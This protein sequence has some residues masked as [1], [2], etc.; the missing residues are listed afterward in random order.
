MKALRQLALLASV[1]SSALLISTTAD[2]QSTR[3]AI[4]VR[5]V[6]EQGQP[7][8]SVPIEVTHLPTGLT[9]TIETNSQG[10]LTASGLPVGGPYRVKVAGG[11]N[12]LAQELNDIFLELGATESVTVPAIAIAGATPTAAEEES[13]EEITITAERLVS[14]LRNGPGR[15][16]SNSDFS[17]VAAISRDF[18]SVLAL[19]SKIQ[20]DTSVP[21][22]PAVSVAG[23]NF[24]FN[25]ITIDGVPQND[26]FG[27]SFNASAVQR[28]P[29]AL[30]AIQALNVNVAPYDVTYGNFLGGN[31]N[32]VTK[33]GTNEFH[34][35]VYGY[36][37]DD[38]LTGGRSGGQDL[39]TDGFDETIF[40]GTLSGP[41]IEDKMFFFVSYE[42][43]D[44]T[45]PA[46]QR[47]LSSEE[48]AVADEVQSIL[49]NDYGFDPGPFAATDNDASDR[50]LAKINW[51][52]TNDHRAVITY[53]RAE[54][55]VIF[56]D[57]PELITLNSNRYNINESIDAYGVQVFSDWSENFSTEFKLGFK[58]VTNRQVS[59]DSS[60]P[61]FQ[62]FTPVGPVLAG[63]DQF[64][65]ANELDNSSRLFKL[66]ADYRLEQ[67]TLTVGIEQERV[68]VRNTF[69]PFSRG[70]VSFAS[71]DDLRNRVGS[72]LLFGGSNSGVDE[73]AIADFAIEYNTAYIQDAWT[74]TDTLTVTLG[75]RLDWINNNDE[76]PFNENFQQRN[77][78]ANTENLDGKSIFSPRLGVNWEPTDRL[79]VRGGVGRFGGGQPIIFLSNA[80]AGNGIT[81]TF[82]NF[83]AP[84]FGEPITS[85]FNQ[86]VQ[87]LPNPEA[88]ANQFQQ[89]LAVNPIG[90][91]DAV[92]PDFQ[93]LSSW[94]YS[95]GLD[96]V[97]DLSSI[98]LGDDWEITVDYIYTEVDNGFDID[99][100]RRSVIGTAPD[101]RPIYDNTDI[102]SGG[103]NAAD[104]VVTN[105]NQGNSHVFTANVDKV[106]DT[107]DYGTFNMS[108]G[109][110]HQDV[111]DV[112]SYGRFVGFETFAFDPQRDLNN[113]DLSNS[114]F[115]IENRIT[116]QLGWEGYLIGDNL[117]RVSL[118]YQGRSGRPVSFVYTG[119]A[120]TFGGNFLADAFSADNPGPNLFYVP[121]GINDPIVTGDAG[122][123][124]NLNE[125]IDNNSCISQYRGQI[126]PRNSCTSPWVN[127]VDLTFVQEFEVADGHVVE[128]NMNIL[129][130]TNLLNRNWGRVDAWTLGVPSNIALATTGLTADGSQFVY[131]APSADIDFTARSRSPQVQVAQLPS[132]Y[133]IQ[134]GLRYRF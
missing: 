15:D 13:V 41:I 6:N 95:L 117:S 46:N 12:F 73:D 28:T 85:A 56:D 59:I 127:T 92:S 132:A 121:T 49:T 32:I 14:Q 129:N 44:T 93:P 104:Y 18:T 64:R 98:G 7:L 35:T 130:F 57:F 133:R 61:A 120:V 87:D 43:F 81:R 17:K 29:V 111:Q 84:F 76:V 88:V 27:L 107:E 50:I 113:P 8:S 19:D 42:R 123:L 68:D 54:D 66:K 31:I 69:L 122:F 124:S 5:V 99:E 71:V 106:W 102:I 109:W 55:D 38:G 101:G 34:G 24:R 128:F 48:Q 134:F 58:D 79:T 37:T 86:A 3:S 77:G 23:A 75:A 125:F 62:V 103:F 116:V 114:L 97:A 108:A 110:T 10:L 16:F 9:R 63:G 51:N 72:T 94:K 78:F 80:Y 40:G 126:I 4:R 74:P 33:E 90:D 89:F 26:N 112:R 83:Y 20:V 119:D 36:Y 96:Y 2:A 11:A 45:I 1:A 100:T 22:G 60:T 91:V 25:T 131:S 47:L 39:A 52:I 30:D 82:A 115:E 21:R 118:F 67:H 65:Q 105:T 53:Q 70:Q